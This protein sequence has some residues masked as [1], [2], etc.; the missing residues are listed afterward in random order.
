MDELKRGD[1]RRI[2]MLTSDKFSVTR[3][4][5]AAGLPSFWTAREL[6]LR[7]MWLRSAVT[8]TSDIKWFVLILEY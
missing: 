7:A 5:R 4:S 6:R 1:I 2:T 8:I 3:A